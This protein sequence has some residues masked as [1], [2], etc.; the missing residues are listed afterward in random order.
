[1]NP[2]AADILMY[3]GIGKADDYHG[4]RTLRFPLNDELYHYNHNHDPKNGQFTFSD[5][6]YSRYGDLLSRVESLKEG[7]PKLTE[8]QIAELMGVKTTQLRA[9]LSLAKAER[10]AYLV[11]AATKLSNE[12]MGAT[13]IGRELGGISESTV[14]SL[15]N[16]KSKENMN[17]AR[18]AADRLKKAV[19]E[20]GMIDV[21]AGVEKELGISREKLAQAL[22]LLS[23]EGYETYGGRVPQVTNPGKQTTLK[24]L[25]PPGT[26]HKEI[27]KFD[28]VNSFS[29]YENSDG[30][31]KK[32][33]DRVFEYPASLDSSRLAIRYAEEGGLDK[34]GVIEIRRGVADLSL[35]ESHYAQVRILVDGT[36]YLKGMAMY[37]DDIPDGKDILFN[38]NK[39]EGTPV[40]GDDKLNTVLKQIKSDPNNPFGALIKADG[41]QSHY[42]DKNGED[43]LSLINKT[44]EEGDWEDYKNRLPSQFLAKQPMPLINN[45]L[46]LA[47]AEKNNEFAEIKEYTNPTIKKQLLKDFADSCDYDS[48]HLQAAA[49]PRQRYQV[50]LPLTTISNNEVYAPNYKDGERVALIR[51]PHGGLFEI[52]I[53]KVNNKNVEGQKTIGTSPKDAVGIN[54]YNA[55]I[56]SGA[57]YDG[58]TVMVIPL[59]NIKVKNDRPLEG[60]IGF[61]AKEEYG[62]LSEKSIGRN[63]KKMK[64]TN[65]EMG[66]ISNLITDMTLKKATEEELVMAVKHSMVVIDAEKHGLDYKRS[67]KENHIADLKRKY[68]GHYDEDG[69]YHEGAATLISRAKSETSVP[70]RQGSPIINEDGT[71]S[72]KTATPDKLYYVNEKGK[73]IMRTQ[74]STQM[75]D[76]DDARTLISELRAPAEIAYANY[77]NKLKALANEARKEMIHTEETPYDSSANKIYKEEYKNLESKLNLAL[78]NA[79]RE[80]QAQRYAISVVNAKKEANPDMKKKELKKI[81]QME[82]T[83]ARNRVDARRHPINFTDREW[84]AIQAGAIT[85]SMLRQIAQ[86]ADKKELRQRATPRKTKELSP[87]KKA[88][89]AAMKRSG[90]NNE[91]IAQRVGCSVST[92]IKYS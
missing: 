92:V 21:G 57:D 71:V 87:A 41:G 48:V 43:H 6:Y 35:G 83:E 28:K 38:T 2:I 59:G 78:L 63:Y 46:N 17:A 72:Y 86:Y 30:E 13:Q 56:L 12:G 79:P 58:D 89:I 64:A 54:R 18:V 31:S 85:K 50:I 67:E 66:K 47:I 91:L 11:D 82:I 34:D 77:A 32:E 27:Y 39:K 88:M 51:Y 7:D 61:D 5:D 22:S 14:R 10:R 76:T 16:E 3:N 81:R 36:H 60:L 45:Q 20:K 25:C 23:E 80:R 70:K 19:D 15:L 9:Q 37:S 68:Q 24:V 73:T 29:D 49:L 65:L 55:G 90:F 74:K 42:K 69:R 62:P 52:P 40:L 26:E 84:E 53:L 75:A 33:K 4:V 44:K 1:M 8:T